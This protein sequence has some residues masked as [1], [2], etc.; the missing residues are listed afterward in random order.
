MTVNPC[1]PF[2]PL[3]FLLLVLGVGHVLSPRLLEMTVNPCDPFD[4]SG[5]LQGVLVLGVG[6]VL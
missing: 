5:F 6:Y 1:D 3:G 2:D 4:P